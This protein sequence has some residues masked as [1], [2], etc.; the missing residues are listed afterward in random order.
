MHRERER[1]Y[2]RKKGGAAFQSTME[3]WPNNEEGEEISL[4]FS[5]FP[6]IN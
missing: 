6:V 1:L 2:T 5:N 3:I 4:T